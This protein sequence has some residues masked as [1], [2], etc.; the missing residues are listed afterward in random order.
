MAMCFKTLVF[1]ADRRM[2]LHRLRELHIFF[3]QR[4]NYI[5]NTEVLLDFVQEPYFTK[6]TVEKEKGIIGQEITMY[7]DL[8]RLAFIFWHD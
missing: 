2:L 7:D 4:I 8:A 1:L 3:L 6:E 5:E